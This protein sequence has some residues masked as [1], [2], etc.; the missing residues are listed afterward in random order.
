MLINY[1]A[2]L[3]DLILK[4]SVVLPR[5]LVKSLRGERSNR[6]FQKRFHNS[7][8]CW[9]KDSASSKEEKHSWELHKL[10]PLKN[11]LFE[12][13]PL[14]KKTVMKN[15]NSK[16]KTLQQGVWEGVEDETTFSLVFQCSSCP[17]AHLLSHVTLYIYCSSLGGEYV[18][19]T[20]HSVE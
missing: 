6:N 9:I 10:H 20:K 13:N 5:L 17:V 12:N 3:K 19:F 4:H 2:P 11:S 18:L 16:V 8:E 1:S 7:T 14:E 15:T